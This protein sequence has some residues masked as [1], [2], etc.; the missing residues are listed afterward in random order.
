MSAPDELHQAISDAAKSIIEKTKLAGGKA[1]GVALIVTYQ[2][3]E[4]HETLSHT[5][6]PIV[7]LLGAIDLTRWSLCKDVTDGPDADF[8]QISGGG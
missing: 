3:E 4:E 8:K 1:V 6:G 2:G 7:P 5:E